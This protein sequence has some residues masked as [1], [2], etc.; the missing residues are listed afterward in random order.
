MTLDMAQTEMTG[1][2]SQL[3]R[4]LPETH[5][6]WGI[7]TRPYRVEFIAPGEEIVFALLGLAAVA[8]LM[9]GCANIASLLLARGTARSQEML[10]RSALGASRGRLIR[11]TLAEGVLLASAGELLGV[12][13][14]FEGLRLL[15]AYAFPDGVPAYAAGRTMGRGRPA[16]RTWCARDRGRGRSRI[17]AAPAA[18]ST[19]GGCTG[20]RSCSGAACS[21]RARSRERS[22]YW[23]WR[24]YFC[25]QPQPQASGLVRH[26][27]PA[28]EGCASGH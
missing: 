27:A 28:D 23:R 12:V 18:G 1:I 10:I 4:E 26:G 21:L 19:G 22:C 11:Q 15:V 2:G 20:A 17:R 13:L 7:I 3:E 8:V 14:S 9:I 24:P 6:G 16:G 25:A 5:Q